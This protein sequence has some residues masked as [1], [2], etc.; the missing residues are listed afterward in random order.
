MLCLSLGSV[1]TMLAFLITDHTF[2]LVSHV[3]NAGEEDFKE[4][5]KEGEK[6]LKESDEFFHSEIY[7]ASIA[8]K[9]SKVLYNHLLEHQ[10]AE[11]VESPPPELIFS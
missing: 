3:D 10:C 11:E 7:K 9:K 2:T 4:D 1:E 6:S 5:A 8:S